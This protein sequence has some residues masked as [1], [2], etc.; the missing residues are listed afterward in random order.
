M[1]G[2]S[3]LPIV[4]LPL[5]RAKDEALQAATSGRRDAFDTEN[6]P[7][8]SRLLE[9]LVQMLDIETERQ[10]FLD[11]PIGGRTPSIF[12]GHIEQIKDKIAEW[13]ELK[14]ELSPTALQTLAECRYIFLLERV[15]GIRDARMADD[16]PDPMDRGGLIHSILREIYN[17][18]A[19]GEC[20]IDAPRYWAVK[21]AAGWIKRTDAGVD[22]IPLAAFVPEYGK[23]YMAFAKR[24]AS[25]RMDAAHLGHPGVW[26]AE[27]QKIL[28]IIL[29]FIR[30]DIETCAPENRFPALFE[31]KFG[32]DTAVDLGEVRLHG[33]IDRVDLIFTDTGN[34]QKVRVLDYKGS[35]RKHSKREEYV[36]DICRNLDC[37]LPVYAFA[38]QQFFFGAFNTPELNAMTEAAYCFYDREFSKIGS[39]LE[40]ST[41]SMDEPDLLEAFLATLYQNIRRLKAGDFAVDPLIETYNDY[42]SVCRTEAVAREDLE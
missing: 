5:C 35:S 1:P 15:F 40:K 24:I 31:L 2:E 39:A 21:T 16:T 19:L 10:A 9:H 36:D 8:A 41:V 37:Q 29:N 42:S 20:G 6:V 28:E 14:R 25:E 7:Q 3:F 27:R 18:V 17:A 4:P 23:E 32:G 12:C 11:A 30:H 34:L 26:K 13:F 38:A 33:I 22:A